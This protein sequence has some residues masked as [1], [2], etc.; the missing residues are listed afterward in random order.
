MHLTWLHRHIHPYVDVL[1]EV[2]GENVK[3][4]VTRLTFSKIALVLVTDATTK[5]GG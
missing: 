2:M 4:Q 5:I 1:F 3:S